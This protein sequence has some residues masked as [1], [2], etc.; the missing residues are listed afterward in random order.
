MINYG[1]TGGG[2]DASLSSAPSHCPRSVSAASPL[3]LHTL[4]DRI[5]PSEPLVH[6]SVERGITYE[7]L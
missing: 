5:E 6:P 2:G 4:L 1:I 7:H 3:Y